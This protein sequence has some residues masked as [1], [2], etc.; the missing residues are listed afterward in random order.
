MKK[1][2]GIVLMISL[3]LTLASC[4]VAAPEQSHTQPSTTP[5]SQQT[6]PVETG[7]A[8][9]EPA[10]TQPTETEPTEPTPVLTE[11]FTFEIGGVTYNLPT[12]YQTFVDHGWKMEEIKKQISAETEVPGYSRQYINLCKDG[13][14]IHVCAINM[15]GNMRMVKD[16][17]IGA[18]T[19]MAND[20]LNFKMDAGVTLDVTVDELQAIYGPASY[21]D[22]FDNYTTVHYVLPPHSEVI[23]YVYNTE[24]EYN[25]V[26]LQNLTPSEDDYTIPQDR[27]PEFFD[28]YVAPQSLSKDASATQFL[29]DGVLYQLPCP[30][31]Q[32]VA[33]GWTVAK[34]PIVSVGAGNGSYGMILQKGDVYLPVGLF[35]FDKI[36]LTSNN[37]AV[38][39][40]DFTSVYLQGQD[41][42]FLQFS[43]NL[44]MDV[45]LETAKKVCKK[46]TQ[47]EGIS[48]TS[49]IRQD[50]LGTWMVR[51]SF[52]ENGDLIV[53]MRSKNWTY[54][55][56]E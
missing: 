2:I 45:E 39:E 43:G 17:D 15:S 51:Y 14:K 13:I 20:G 18:V 40:I 21:V 1:W 38:Y 12:P 50:K 16:C 32:F 52:Y 29:L 41:V 27:R 8:Q 46:F 35:N 9:T 30:L 19:I 28:N 54:P 23:F 48:Y 25:T 5:T 7:P 4:G 42:S 49:L 36:E 34:D 33:N 6:E 53:T 11:N 10:Q 26:T 47:T 37:C 24:T 22:T 31:E 56:K 44:G 55:T 3:M